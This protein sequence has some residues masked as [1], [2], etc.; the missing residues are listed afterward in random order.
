MKLKSILKKII[1]K[2]FIVKVREFENLKY[3]LNY[4]NFSKSTTIISSQ[5]TLD[6]VEELLRNRQKGIYLRFGDGDIFILKKIGTHR[7]QQHDKKLSAELEEAICLSGEGVVKSIA[8]HSK[9][10]GIDDYMEPGIH[11]RPDWEAERFLLLS[12]KY[13]IGSPIYSP[14]ALHYQIIYNRSAAIRFFNILRSFEPIFVGS[15]NNQT[16]IVKSSLNS[17]VFIKTPHRSGYDEVDRIE[18]EIVRALDVRGKSYDVVVFS[19]G[20]TA[21]S[22]IKRLY[23]DSERDLFLFDLGSVIDLFHGR[24]AWTW[25]RKSGI[26]QNYIDAFLNELD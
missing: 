3:K 15:N 18:S 5:K 12:Y 25:V 23:L 16:D 11:E 21:K 24:M 8:I 13:F 9:K 2:W 20:S 6:K 19:C 7:N 10:F 1:P 17:N 22:L 4:L 26:D 14:V